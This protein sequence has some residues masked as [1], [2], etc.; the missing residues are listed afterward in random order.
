M[1]FIVQGGNTQRVLR[2]IAC[3]QELTGR[4]WESVT[5]LSN[6]QLHCL[7]RTV[8]WG[9]WS[10]AILLCS[11]ILES[12]S[13]AH[14][15]S[16]VCYRGLP[17]CKFASVLPPSSPSYPKVTDY[18]GNN[19]IWRVKAKQCKLFVSRVL[20][21]ACLSQSWSANHK[22]ASDSIVTEGRPPHKKIA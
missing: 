12:C 4:W 1:M 18:S 6:L 22:T 16:W 19:I 11:Q 8:L 5:S 14:H 17:P 20:N 9:L 2:Y 3:E 10:S 15:L 13:T 21:V 7:P